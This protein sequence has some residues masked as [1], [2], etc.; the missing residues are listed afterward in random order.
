MG[1]KSKYWLCNWSTTWLIAMALCYIY[2]IYT[3]YTQF[4]QCPTV[5]SIVCESIHIL[6][7][8]IG[9]GFFTLCY[10]YSQMRWASGWMVGLLIGIYGLLLYDEEYTEH[11]QFAGLAFMCIYGFT[12]TYA[13]QSIL[14]G[15]ILSLQTFFIGGLAIE[16]DIIGFEVASIGLFAITYLYV[17][18][19]IDV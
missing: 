15:V 19:F 13:L 11:Y 5:S 7:A 8:M 3:V 10:E 17:H 14:C 16:T 9:M 18:G 4:D 12:I 2:P 1:S 6:L